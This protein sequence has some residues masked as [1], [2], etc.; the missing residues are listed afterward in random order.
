MCHF[1]DIS[2]GI[3]TCTVDTLSRKSVL[4]KSFS[5]LYS[6]LCMNSFTCGITFRLQN[7]HCFYENF[8]SCAKN[9]LK[10]AMLLE[11]FVHKVSYL[12]TGKKSLRSGLITLL[13]RFSFHFEIVKQWQN[14][15]LQLCGMLHADSQMSVKLLQATPSCGRRRGVDVE[16]ATYH[17]TAMSFLYPLPTD[18][19]YSKSSTE[20][21][22]MIILCRTCNFPVN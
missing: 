6:L 18:K 9:I 14:M 22:R 1:V 2:V 11:Y 12:E 21:P 19:T 10:P 3:W 8:I 7:N 5:L 16:L 15:A 20:S 13:T 4:L 17:S